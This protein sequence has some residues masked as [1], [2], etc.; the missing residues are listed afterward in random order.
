[1]ERVTHITDAGADQDGH[2]P[3][4][5][6][7]ATA[8][9]Q[10]AEPS[11]AALLNRRIESINPTLFIAPNARY[12]DAYAWYLLVCVLDILL[13]Y[14][15]LTYYGAREVNAIAQW[16]IDHW[17]WTGLVTLKFATVVVVILICEILG[18]LRPAAGRMVS[19][20]AVGISAVPVVLTMAQMSLLGVPDDFVFNDLPRIEIREPAQRIAAGPIFSIAETGLTTH[21]GR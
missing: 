15:V 2:R 5:S 7:R 9:A 8:V 1:M 16:A 19:V 13:T 11:L 18:R 21:F 3:D 12:S 14:T 4:Q 6:N 17:S 10:A 20:L